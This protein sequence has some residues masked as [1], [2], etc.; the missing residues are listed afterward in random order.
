MLLPFCIAAQYDHVGRAIA[1]SAVGSA[2]AASAKLNTA[3]EAMKRAAEPETLCQYES[4]A[5]SEVKSPNLQN[6]SNC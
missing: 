4:I 1:S 3:E 5:R 2:E 6:N